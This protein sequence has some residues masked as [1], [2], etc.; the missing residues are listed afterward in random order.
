MEGIKG[1]YPGVSLLRPLTYSSDKV[2]PYCIRRGALEHFK[3]DLPDDVR[4]RMSGHKDYQSTL[5]RVDLGAVLHKRDQNIQVTNAVDQ[6]PCLQIETSTLPFASPLPVLKS[7]D[8]PELAQLRDKEA[9]PLSMDEYHFF[10]NTSGAMETYS[11]EPNT[12]NVTYGKHLV[13]CH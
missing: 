13:L 2:T 4:E 10:K 3:R 7:Y 11:H 8:E 5:I 6:W 12:G 1:M 9:E